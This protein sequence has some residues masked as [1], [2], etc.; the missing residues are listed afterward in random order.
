MAIRR[1]K[2]CVRL[3]V[4]GILA[5][6]LLWLAVILVAPTGWAKRRVV[7][8]LESRSGRSVGLERL[9]VC[10]LGGVRLT[11]L[12][13]GAPDGWDD[14]WLKVGELRLNLGL[15][16]ILLG[17]LEPTRLE[18]DLVRLRVLRRKDGSLELAD[19]LRPVSGPTTGSTGR[20]ADRTAARQIAF[21]VRHTSVTVIDEPTESRFQFEDVEG[22]GECDGARIAVEQLRGIVNGGPFRLA[23][24]LDRTAHALLLEAQFRADG[25]KLD[26]GMRVLRYVVPVLAGAPSGLSGRLQTDLYV[27]GRGTTWAELSQSAVG[28]GVILLK[29]IDLEGAP[30]VAELSKL[31][32]LAGPNRLATIHSDFIVK[33]RRITTDHLTLNIARIPLTMSGWTDL[34]GRLEYRVKLAGLGERL[35]SRA[36]RIL[37]DLNLD[38]GSLTSL[39]LHGTLNQVMVQVN[40]L[41]IDTGLMQES[42]PRRDD[43]ERLRMLGRQL[44]DKILR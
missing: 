6:V 19:L 1:W 39:T 29:E 28:Q 31:A 21:Q 34:D 12:E 43:R 26:Q 18:A 36:R 13:I 42:G 11:N 5:P 37:G 10:P 14:P 9:S 44:R 40:G 20:A 23:A 33:D 17:R 25:V 41:S 35:P 7:A 30:L 38:V 32:E 22:D 8:V 4:L 3:L 16:Q 27:Q 24:Q 2:W 15:F